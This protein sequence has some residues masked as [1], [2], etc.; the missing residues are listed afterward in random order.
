MSYILTP[1]QLVSTLTYLHLTTEDYTIST[2][3]LKSDAFF[4]VVNDVV[5]EL[6]SD[7]INEL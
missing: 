3:T 4:S 6:I 2:G 7:I 5:S 1:H